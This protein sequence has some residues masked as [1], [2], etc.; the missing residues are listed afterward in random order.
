M[1]ISQK[2]SQTSTLDQNRSHKIEFLQLSTEDRVRKILEFL[3]KRNII[4][5]YKLFKKDEG[6]Q[7]VV[8]SMLA[9]LELAK[10]KKIEIIQ[11]EDSN[12]FYIKSKKSLNE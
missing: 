10:E 6:K 7:G 2:Y 8:V 9:S 1:L 3:E 5:F 4:E 12:H 11:N